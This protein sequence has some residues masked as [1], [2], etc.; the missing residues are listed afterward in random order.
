MATYP[1][2]SL[3]RE[4]DTFKLWSHKVSFCDLSPGQSNGALNVPLITLVGTRRK[5]IVLSHILGHSK[6]LRP[7]NQVHLASPRLTNSFSPEVYIDCE[8]SVGIPATRP[9]SPACTS[10]TILE[11]TS[12]L[13]MGYSL[14]S[15]VFAPLSDVICYFAADLRG[16]PGVCSILAFQAVQPRL[17]N[18]PTRALPQILVVVDTQASH[19]NPKAVRSKLYNMVLE[20]MNRLKNYS[21]KDMA[22]EDFK[23][24]F[25]EM[26]IFG[27]RRTRSTTQSSKKLQQQ[28]MSLSQE[29]QKG[30]TFARY[31]F[32]LKHIEALVP[33]LLRCFCTRQAGFDFLRSTRPSG[34]DCRDMCW[35]LTALFNLIPDE[36]WIWAVIVPLFASSVFLPNYP[37]GS[38]GNKA[39]STAIKD[40]LL[41][42]RFKERVQEKLSEIFLRFESDPLEQSSTRQHSDVLKSLWP[43][44]SELKTFQSCLSCL[45]SRPE[46]V[47]DCGHAI[48]NVCVRR[49]GQRLSGRHSFYLPHCVLCGRFQSAEKA[50]FDLVPPTAGIRI[51][52]ID[53]GGIRGVIPLVYLEH[54]NKEMEIFGS[55]VRNHFDYVCGTSA[56]G[57]IAIG[58]FLMRWT[59]QECLSRFEEIATRTFK[60]E[61]EKIFS[62]SRRVHNMFRTFLRDHRY[63]LSP[64][65][66]AFGNGFETAIKMFNP[67]QAD[68]KVAVT[69]TTV[70]GNVS[71]LHTNYNG[72]RSEEHIDY[73]HIRAATFGHDIS[74]SDAAASTSA[75][76]YYFKSKHVSKLD[77]YQDGG[78][79][80]NNPAFVSTWECARIWPDKGQIFEPNRNQVDHYISLGTG[81]SQ[82]NR[83]TVGPHS[84]KTDHFVHRLASW[85]SGSLDSEI[86]WNRFISCVPQSMRERCL[87]LNLHF[88]GPE[89][90]LS[91]VASI[92]RLKQQTRDAI[93][94]DRRTA[95]AR[96]YMIAGMFYFELDQ[97]SRV[98]GGAY[99]CSGNVL[100]RV[101]L[102][103]EGQKKFYATLRDASTTFCMQGRTIGRVLGSPRIIPIFR[104]SLDFVL[105]SMEGKLEICVKGITTQ[106]MLISGMPVT[107]GTLIQ[108]Q[109]LDAPFGTLDGHTERPLPT[110]P[111]KRKLGDAFL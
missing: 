67:L 65:E 87:R 60:A 92:G 40:P 29:V 78:L 53:G 6:I 48:C 76:P 83:Y 81:T 4:N 8:L 72:D 1:W 10:Q 20:E 19:F 94:S 32:S 37:P 34:F 100:S 18:L 38:H 62:I 71:C 61:H 5:S 104:L 16:I 111:S 52:S 23:S 89:P 58:V 73:Q 68:T 105:P 103:I 55:P 74:I 59:P 45:V 44:L 41:Q 27:A 11:P 106:P 101:P 75:A 26:F 56:G 17:H 43:H 51:L 3:S 95:D 88:P 31:L 42:S 84:P 54:M 36:A 12:T 69:A 70:R 79:L 30:R 7:H 66:R 63:N 35:H 28:I 99:Q 82:S 49:F 14:I 96:N 109:G 80:Y 91:D 90:G 50:N 98:E 47:F 86:L 107:L 85:A 39:I 25:G 21:N 15:N 97:Y 93:W 57:L 24:R 2:I 13:S 9:T 110:V 102:D 108:S 64:I 22:E 33:Q 77:T 46:K